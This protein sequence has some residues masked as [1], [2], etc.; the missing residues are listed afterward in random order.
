MATIDD[1]L[2][3][4]EAPDTP[5]TGE[6]G[7]D[8]IKVLKGLEAVRKRPGMYIGDT[9]DGSG[10]HHMVFEVVDNSVDEA[11]AGHCDTVEITLHLDGSCSVTDNG[12]GIPVGDHGDGRSAAEVVL[13]ELHAGGKFDQNSYK[14]SGG[15]HG[16][17]VSVVNALSEWLN[18]EVHRDGKRHRL[19]FDHGK[20]T[21]PIEILGSTDTTGTIVHFKP[22]P[23]IFSMTDFS[24]DML[25][26]RFREMAYLNRGLRLVVAD[27]GHDKSQVFHFEGGIVSFVEY[28]SKSR[29]SLVEA[30]I[31]VHSQRTVDDNRELEVEV[32]L[33]WTDAYSENVACFTNNIRNRDG[34]THLTGFRTAI[35]RVINDFATKE[36]L[37]KKFKG[38]LSGD[39]IRE[40]VTAVISVKLPDPKFSS[41]TK[42]KLVSSEVTPVVQSI[43]TEGLSTWLAENPQEAKKV[44][45]K[46]VDSARAREAARKARDMVRRKGVLESSSLPGKL[47]DC[48]ERDP[49]KCELFIVEGESAGGSAK[50]GRERGYQ[51]ILPLRGKILNVERARFD[52]MLNS[53]EIR[54]LIT[55]L[56]TG[57]GA[58]SYSI[59][60]L[61]YHR[62][63]IMT[64]ADVD[65]L[66][67]RTLLLTFFYRQFRELIDRGYLYIAQPPLYRAKKGKTIKYL[68]DDK[69]REAW[70]IEAGAKDASVRGGD[71]EVSGEELTKLLRRII[72][73]RSVMGRL[74]KRLG[75]N[76]DPRVVAAFVKGSHVN[77]DDLNDEE[78]LKA[79]I[80]AAGQ[81]LTK[82]Y[83]SMVQPTFEVKPTEDSDKFGKF[84]IEVRSRI[85]GVDKRTIV[86]SRMA[87][88]ADY[89]LLGKRMVELREMLGKGPYEVCRGQEVHIHEDL[90]QVLDRIF[91]LGMK[92]VQLNRFKGLGEMN[93]EQLWETSMD[94]SARRLLQVRVEETERAD[95]VFSVLMGDQVEPRR[96]FITENALNVRNLDL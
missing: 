25:I 13:T 39:D 12:R 61:R 95:H 93:P 19:N 9:D 81:W 83:P 62:V 23:D 58:E 96:E 31:F 85:S 35:T 54:V 29:T 74:S 21:G 26:H 34:G 4:A 90:E 71:K 59:D 17:G 73:M 45:G 91:S 46:A 15:L 2:E 7:A 70:L 87:R 37:L 65:G 10:L 60:K 3:R 78:S 72:E 6:Y 47:A 20:A 22:D 77:P 43:L 41:Q 8:A 92:G 63:I 68:L 69:E 40:G 84:E 80:D 1:V 32:A 88:G 75:V 30:P 48:Q 76:T 27:E 5:D 14:V 16:V 57:I 51:A 53:E 52:R 11:L 18:L 66:H 38:T 24:Y 36:G 64:D 50:G 56:G 33:Q 49:S 42:D 89:V 55:A 82:H 44:V 79:S 86:G 94:P 28:M 67:I